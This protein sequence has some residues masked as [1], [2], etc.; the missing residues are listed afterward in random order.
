MDWM[1][2]VGTN[3]WTMPRGGNRLGLPD[4]TGLEWL[5]RYGSVVATAHDFAST[6][7]VNERGLGAHLLWRT[8]AGADHDFGSDVD[9]GERDLTTPG[10]AASLWAQLFLDTCATVAEADELMRT[11][12][13]QLC[14]LTDLY[15]GEFGTVHLALDDAAGDSMLVEYQ[16]GRPNIHHDRHI[17]VMTN[18]PSFPDQFELL[19]HY[20]GFGGEAA[21]PGTT[22]PADRFVRAAYY[23]AH[24]PTPPDWRSAM[25][26]LAS[27]MRTAAQPVTTGEESQV[28]STIWRTMADLTNRRYYFESSDSPYLVWV[29][30][31][32]VG[33]DEDAAAQRLDLHA[34][35]DLQGDVSTRFAPAEEFAFAMPVTG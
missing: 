17:A 29:S 5:V 31:D 28:S 32:Q 20:Q 10:V 2:D 26:G 7:G 34:G 12:S 22:E 1:R 30:L 6:D 18:S 33:L 24:L 14:P 23:R 11:T 19:H 4:G 3:L 21:L 13:F 25:A 27:V 8:S 9:F 16:H 35:R 15:R